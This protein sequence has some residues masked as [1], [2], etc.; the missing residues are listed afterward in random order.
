MEVK[1]IKK[2]ADEED[3]YLVSAKMD[4]YISSYSKQIW[5]LKQFLYK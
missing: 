4:D 2:A 3:N 1:A 5:M